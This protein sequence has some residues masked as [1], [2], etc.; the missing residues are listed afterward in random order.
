MVELEY[1]KKFVAFIDV[2]GFSSLVYSQTNNA[3]KIYF[4][5]VIDEFTKEL[6]LYQFEFYLISDSIVISTETSKKNFE[7]LIRTI[8]KLQMKLITRGIL[9]RGGISIGDLYINRDSNI[10]VGS[11]LIN[12]YNLESKAQYPRIVIDRKIIPEFYS[13][14][15]ELVKNS[16]KRIRITPPEPYLSDLPY[17][18]FTYKLAIVMQPPKLN[19][20]KLLL[21]TN[22]YKNENVEKYLWL[23]VHILSGFKRQREFIENKKNKNGRDIK[24]LKLIDEFTEYVEKI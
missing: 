17:I 2:L 15:Q 16:G 13:N 4:D 11:G 21:S 6:K 10:I 20:V 5:Y 14:S 22:L 7:A 19:T 18:D 9:V 23:R 3:I 8:T 1:S 24:R 12:A